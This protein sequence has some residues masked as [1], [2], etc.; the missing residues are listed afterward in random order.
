MAVNK[1]FDSFVKKFGCRREERYSKFLFENQNC[2]QRA[3]YRNGKACS[4]NFWRVEIE[5]NEKRQI[6]NLFSFNY[7]IITKISGW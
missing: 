2:Q 5:K 6:L 1:H 4:E 7:Q 3:K